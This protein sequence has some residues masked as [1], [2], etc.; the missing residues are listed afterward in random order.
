MPG[1]AVSP[2]AEDGSV[3]VSWGSHSNGPGVTNAIGACCAQRARDEFAPVS[4]PA[5]GADDP[6]VW[7]VL[8]DGRTV[9]L[10]ADVVALCERARQGCRSPRLFT[11]SSGAQV[12]VFR[13]NFNRSY[14]AARGADGRFAKPRFASASAVPVWTA[15]PGRV[16]FVTSRGTTLYLTTR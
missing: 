10:A 7:T 4:T 3:V 11:W 1:L 8:D 5:A 6:K 16:N 2:I 14:V 13:R 15:K 12:L 9:R